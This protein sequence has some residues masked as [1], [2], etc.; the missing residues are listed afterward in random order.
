MLIDF[1]SMYEVYYPDWIANIVIICKKNRKWRVCTD[2]KNLNKACSKESFPLPH[3]N[4]LINATIG[5]ELLNFM[6]AFSGYKKILVHLDDQEKIAFITERGTFCYKVMPLKLKNSRATYQR[7]VNKMF[8]ELLGNTIK[9]YIEDMLV[10]SL[11]TKQRLDN[12]HHAFNILKWYNMRL[13]PTTCSLSVAL[14]NSLDIWRL[15]GVLKPNP[16]KFS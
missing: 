5:H 7:L 16:I 11:I 10:K 9:V 4:M 1:G 2:F 14:G 3:I 15:N 6:D 8:T 12:L 13:N